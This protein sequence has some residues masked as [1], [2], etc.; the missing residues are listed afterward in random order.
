M[1]LNQKTVDRFVDENLDITTF[2]EANRC[3]DVAC[4]YQKLACH[5][6]FRNWNQ[7]QSLL[8]HRYFWN[9]QLA[10][11]AV[12]CFHV[13]LKGIQTREGTIPPSLTL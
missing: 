6:L 1:A 8:L 4:I 10:G 11:Y 2:V 5:K 13:H 12:N 3:K 7:W 9:L